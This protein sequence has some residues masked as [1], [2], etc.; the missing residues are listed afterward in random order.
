HY[1]PELQHEPKRLMSWLKQVGIRT[2]Q[3]IAKW[4]SVGFT[5]GVLNTDNMS[6]LGLTLDYGPFGFMDSYQH[7]FVCNHT[8]THGRYAFS[9]QPRIGLWNLHALV[10]SLSFHLTQDETLE[11]LETYTPVFEE[12]WIG[13]M[14]AKLGLMTVQPDDE[15]LILDLLDLLDRNRIDYTRFMRQLS[16]FNSSA[17]PHDNS[18]LRDTFPDRDSFDAWANRYAR[19]LSQENSHPVERALHMNQVNPKYILRNYLADLAIQQA[20]QGDFSEIDRLL[21]LLQ[22]PYDEQP[23]NEHYAD[24]PPEWASSLDLSCSS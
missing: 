3:L 6:I 23:D 15:T 7:N 16:R 13:I 1:Y 10:Q 5:H 2:A 24:L 11:I 19:R 9:Q 14:R 17:Q 21:A 20:R 18:A 8:D 22:H 12:T 4:Q